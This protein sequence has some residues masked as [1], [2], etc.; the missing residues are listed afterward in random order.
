MSDVR[1][2]TVVPDANVLIHGKSLSELPWADL[3]RPIIEVLLV[4]PTIAEIDKLKVETGRPKKIARQLS[5]DIRALIRAGGQTKI[6]NSGPTVSK[7]VELRRAATEPLHP[8][9]NS[10]TLTRRS[11]TT[12]SS[13]GRRNSMFYC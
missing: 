4:P 2:L 13:F 3:S 11:S 1:P 6:R 7:R 12:A 9:L 10:I 5:S 8:T